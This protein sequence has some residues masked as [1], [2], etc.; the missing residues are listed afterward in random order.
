MVKSGDMLDIEDI[1]EILGVKLIGAVPDDE[2]V[3]IST[4][5]GE[6]VLNHDQS[7]ASKAYK[8][9]ARR[10]DGEDVE[11]MN[12]DIQDSFFKRLQKLFTGK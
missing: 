11:F 12:L 1:L 8:N 5:K 2:S 3:V 4:N 10:I 9:I 7:A 6:P